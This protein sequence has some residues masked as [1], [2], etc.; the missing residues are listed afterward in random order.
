MNDRIEKIKP[1]F[2]EMQI[3]SDDDNNTVIYIKVSFPNKWSI[4]NEIRNEKVN[5]ITMDDLTNIFFTDL[6]NGYDILF[7]AIEYTIKENKEAEERVNLFHIKVKELESLFKDETTTLEQLKLLTFVFEKPKRN[8]K[9]NNTKEQ[10][11]EEIN[12]INNIFKIEDNIEET[13]N[14]SD[15]E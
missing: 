14:N 10:F 8:K 7:D 12:K 13:E 3:I 6:V 2:I 15:Y 5:V 11:Q 1:Y 9:T 4:P